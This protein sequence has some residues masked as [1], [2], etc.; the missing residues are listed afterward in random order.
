MARHPA[1]NLDDDPEVRAVRQERPPTIPAASNTTPSAGLGWLTR[2]EADRDR[3]LR[4]ARDRAHTRRTAA[5]E[6]RTYR[7]MQS[8]RWGGW[9]VIFLIAASCWLCGFACALFV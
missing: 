9:T 3:R 1:D 2:W 4:E 8:Y 5:E 6:S 7:R